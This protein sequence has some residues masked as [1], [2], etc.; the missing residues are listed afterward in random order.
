MVAVETEDWC[1]AMRCCITKDMFVIDE[2]DGRLVVLAG[3]HHGAMMIHAGSVRRHGAEEQHHD[4]G[5]DVDDVAYQLQT[6]IPIDATLGR[7]QCDRRVARAQSME[8]ALP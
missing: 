6:R 4:Q 3:L 8:R 7:Y 5:N 1:A 2:R